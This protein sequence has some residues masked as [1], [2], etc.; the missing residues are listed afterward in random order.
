MKQSDVIV[1]G[2][3]MVGLTLGLALAKGGFRSRWSMPLPPAKT[4]APEFDGRVSALAYATVRMLQALGVWPHLARDAQPIREIL[5]TDGAVGRRPR[6]SRCI[7]MPRKWAPTAWAISPRTGISA[8]RFMP[9]SRHEKNLTLI[10]PAAVTIAD[11][12]KAPH[13]TRAAQQWRA[14]PGR[15]GRRRRWPRFQVARRAG[16]RRDR[17]VLSADR[18]RRHRAA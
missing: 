2:G 13:V 9:P 1:C 15:A 5:V 3:G 18:H 12:E 7:S 11:G 10:A 6:L 17:L 8:P 4:V 14:N 16:H